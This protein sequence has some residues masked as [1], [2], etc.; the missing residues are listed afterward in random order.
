MG[1]AGTEKSVQ[2]RHKVWPAP[3]FEDLKRHFTRVIL[4]LYGEGEWNFECISMQSTL[5]VLF[6]YKFITAFA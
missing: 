5:S 4:V 3:L 2:F 1:F 6:L